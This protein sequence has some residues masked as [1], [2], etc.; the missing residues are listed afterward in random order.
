MAS[1]APPV[2]VNEP[3][4]LMPLAPSPLIAR[5]STPPESVPEAVSLSSARPTDFSPPSAMSSVPPEIVAAVFFLERNTP[6]CFTSSDAPTMV[7]V[8]ASCV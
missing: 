8:P 6:F 3:S 5:R 4:P 1:I 2:I 7:S